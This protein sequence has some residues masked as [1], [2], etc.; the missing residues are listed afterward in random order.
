MRLLFL[1]VLLLPLPCA[2]PSSAQSRPPRDT[3]VCFTLDEA[4]LIHDSLWSAANHRSKRAI[5]LTM[6]RNLNEQLNS[7]EERERLERTRANENARALVACSTRAAE[8]DDLQRKAR[9]RLRL[10]GGGLV[11]GGAVTFMATEIW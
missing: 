1:L 2:T 10:F 8:V 7:A 5:Y 6:V 3:V 4:G 11:L 9:Q